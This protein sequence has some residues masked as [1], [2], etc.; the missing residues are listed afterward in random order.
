[1]SGVLTAGLGAASGVVNISGGFAVDDTIGGPGTASAAVNFET[2]GDVMA[3]IS[4]GS[5]DA[6][7]WIVPKS[8]APGAYEIMAH[9][10][11]GDAVGGD[12]LDTWHALTSLRS[13]SLTQGVVGEKSANLTVSIRLG[14]VTLSS[15]TVTLH[16]Q[17]I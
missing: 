15:G 8:M 7:D 12:P 1:M 16:A 6:G 3:V 14:G 2:D 10:N 13:W 17:V 5:S 11:S 9:Q 4:T